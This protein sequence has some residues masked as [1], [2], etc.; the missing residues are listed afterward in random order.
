MA[1]AKLT[2][3][4]PEGNEW[5]LLPSGRNSFMEYFNINVAAAVAPAVMAPSAR[6]FQSLAMRTPARVAT[7]SATTHISVDV[8]TAFREPEASCD[9][10]F[11]GSARASAAKMAVIL[12]IVILDLSVQN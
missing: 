12:F 4:C 5:V 1:V 2:D 6:P 7:G 11:Q 3:V 8:A 10:A 9:I